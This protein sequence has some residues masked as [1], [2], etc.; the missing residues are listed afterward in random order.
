MH[1]PR[2]PGRFG[3]DARLCPAG[4]QRLP[5]DTVPPYRRIYTGLALPHA[6]S[7]AITLLRGY[8]PGDDAHGTDLATYRAVVRTRT[9]HHTSGPVRQILDRLTNA[10]DDA[11]LAA[12]CV[13][14]SHLDRLTNRHV[15]RPAPG[16]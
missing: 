5:G 16:A 11:Y 6:A 10:P 2:R 4:A 1:R 15:D 13:A 7:C 3:G 8:H 14:L 12:V 9:A